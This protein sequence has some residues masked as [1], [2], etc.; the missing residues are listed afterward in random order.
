M[1]EREKEKTTMKPMIWLALISCVLLAA[2]LWFRP[3]ISGLGNPRVPDATGRPKH[4][5]PDGVTTPGTAG[6]TR[7]TSGGSTGSGGGA[8]DFTGISHPEALER[9]ILELVNEE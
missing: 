3:V 8:P 2:F 9:K 6:P 1:K 7:D 4:P 5:V